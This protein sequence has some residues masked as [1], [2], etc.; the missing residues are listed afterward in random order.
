MLQERRKNSILLYFLGCLFSF[1]LSTQRYIYICRWYTY[2][3]T[4]AFVETL[5]DLGGLYICRCSIFRSFLYSC[6]FFL[7][8]YFEIWP[9]YQGIFVFTRSIPV[10][11]SAYDNCHTHTCLECMEKLIC[12]WWWWCVDGNLLMKL[13][14]IGWTAVDCVAIR[15]LLYLY[16]DF[17]FPI[18]SRRMKI[19]S[20][21][22]W[23]WIWK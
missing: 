11:F 16:V 23:R 2:R 6:Q 4:I 17:F 3:P 13:R 19:K 8:P 22:E 14:V 18:H 9:R 7:F 1:F 5:S 12:I 21:E 20:R 15:A 10:V